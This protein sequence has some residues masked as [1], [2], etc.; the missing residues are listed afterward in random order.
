MNK[1]KAKGQ[2]LFRLGPD[3]IETQI[4]DRDYYMQHYG[5]YFSPSDAELFIDH[6]FNTEFTPNIYDIFD[7]K[8]FLSGVQDGYIIDDDGH[9]A[10]IFVDGYISNLGL[11]TDNLTQGEFLVSAEV[12][13]DICNEFKVEVNWANK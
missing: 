7:G 8:E 11:S 13:E 2:I 6:K 4:Y 9:I 10:D 5:Q 1:Y 3:G 12:W